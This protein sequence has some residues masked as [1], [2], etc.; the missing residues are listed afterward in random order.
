MMR[1]SLLLALL[2]S[3]ALA[4]DDGLYAPCLVAHDSTEAYADAFVAE[5]WVLAEGAER[6][7]AI[8][9]PAEV[10][11]RLISRAEP[12]TTLADL[13]ETLDRVRDWAEGHMRP[14]AVLTRDGI[15]VAVG[16]RSGERPSLLCI[17]SAA[18]L[19]VVDEML[20]DA[21]P[22]P[23]SPGFTTVLLEL[24]PPPGAHAAIVEAFR[25]TRLVDAPEPL[26]GTEAILVQL[27][28]GDQP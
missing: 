1:A 5:G 20:G 3:P 24:P 7:A 23:Y 19:P 22:A 28:F 27:F 16:V 14:A 11:W 8:Q 17:L 26:P 4:Q 9:G 12:E 10:Y 6:E 21:E 25:L 18:D 2:A 13:E 15:S